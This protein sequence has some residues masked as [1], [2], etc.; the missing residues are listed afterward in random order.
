MKSRSLRPR[1]GPGERH[2]PRDVAVLELVRI[3]G[4]DGLQLLEILLQVIHSDHG[5]AFGRQR[6][7]FPRVQ[8]TVQKPFD[9]KSRPAQDVDRQPR[10][11]F[12]FRVDDDRDVLRK[13]HPG[14]IGQIG[15]IEL[16]LT[17][18]A[19]GRPQRAS[20]VACRG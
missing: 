4:I 19:N 9:L 3:A 18:P 11:R 12:R 2:R 10:D 15:A 17:A 13:D 7:Y 20:A 5:D 1:F 14:A 6:G 16:Q 8:S